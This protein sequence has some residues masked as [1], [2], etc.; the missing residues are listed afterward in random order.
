MLPCFS[1][2][3]SDSKLSDSRLLGSFI[4]FRILL[5]GCSQR[6]LGNTVPTT[7]VFIP[8][9]AHLNYSMFRFCVLRS[10]CVRGVFGVTPNCTRTYTEMITKF[11]RNLCLTSFLCPELSEFITKCIR[12]V[13]E[14]STNF[15][16]TFHELITDLS[17]SIWPH[18]VLPLRGSPVPGHMAPV[19]L[20]WAHT[21]WAHTRL[22]GV[23]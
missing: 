5:R 3:F 9:Y 6:L 21:G 11:S 15:P 23:A 12:K 19:K 14:N 1:Q 13:Y 22:W 20:S 18:P 2:A 4:L 8:W 10:W 16:R 17:R 7:S